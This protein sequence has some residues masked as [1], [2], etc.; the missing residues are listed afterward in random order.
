M[1]S[2]VSALC[3]ALTA[4]WMTTS[5]IAETPPTEPMRVPDTE[6]LTV[7]MDE[8]GLNIIGGRISACSLDNKTRLSASFHFVAHKADITQSLQD[9]RERHFQSLHTATKSIADALTSTINNMTA[10]EMAEGHTYT[11]L[12]D[13][14]QRTLQDQKYA[15]NLIHGYSFFP[16]AIEGPE[17]NQCHLEKPSF[18]I[19]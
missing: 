15:K 9:D 19:T 10:A 17:T 18:A 1:F 4:T 11:D 16:T 14:I 5:A 13:L 6:S 3:T 7:M 2:R 8:T 12:V